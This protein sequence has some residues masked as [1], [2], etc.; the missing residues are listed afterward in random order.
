[1]SMKSGHAVISF[2]FLR[3]IFSN[4]RGKKNFFVIIF[5]YQGKYT[6]VNSKLH[7]RD[8]VIFYSSFV[9]KCSDTRNCTK[10]KDIDFWP[11]LLLQSGARNDCKVMNKKTRPYCVKQ[12][13]KI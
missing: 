8:Y 10:N 3:R 12:T 6:T 5:E 2:E 13:V 9:S 4:K 7:Q 11:M 1:M